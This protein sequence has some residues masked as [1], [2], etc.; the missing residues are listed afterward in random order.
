MRHLQKALVGAAMLLLVASGAFAQ[1]LIFDDSL[2]SCTTDNCSSLNLPGTILS[3]GT[4]STGNFLINTF[5]GANEC[6]RLDVSSQGADLEMVVI[7]PNGAIYRNDDSG[8]PSC[9]LCPTVKINPTPNNGWYTVHLTHFDG[10]PVTVNFTLL[11][12]RYTLNNAN[13]SGST[14]PSLTT[15]GAEQAVQAGKL[16]GDRLEAPL[17]DEPGY[18]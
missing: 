7:A 11:Y 13:C 18:E 2:S 15:Q 14:S 5:A 1:T 6:L 8:D 17:P 9:P 12:G 4:V 10:T 16:S 3:F